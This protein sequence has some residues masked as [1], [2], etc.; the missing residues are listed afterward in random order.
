MKNLKKLFALTTALLLLLTGCS[1]TTNSDSTN[2][3]TAETS[4]DKTAL[5]SILDSGVL[6]VAT[7][8]DY[9]PMEYLDENQD[10]IGSDISLANYIAE[11]LGVTLKIE[12]MDF[13]GTL[14]AVDTGKVD[15]AISGFG[16]KEDRAESYELSIGY[17]N[18][19]G[20]ESTCH[21]ILIKKEDY[22]KYKSLDDFKGTTIAAQSA[23]LQEM[24]VNDQIEDVTIEIVQQIDQGVLALQSG[25]VQGLALSCDIAKGYGNTMDDTIVADVLFD[26]SIY[27]DYSGNVI[28]AKKGETDLIEKINEILKEVNESGKF[29]VWHADAK[30]KA[31]ELGIEFE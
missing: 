30:T 10:P 14:T 3:A 4:T 12:T 24:Y 23:S 22:D 11:Q 29:E 17:N 31:K 27:D 15:L 7:S 25:K 19:E 2:N 1:N 28:A 26:L 13:S 9:P 5:E 16:W 21:T 6:V 18:T 20:A 8:P